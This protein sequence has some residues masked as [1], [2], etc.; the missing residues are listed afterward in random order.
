MK[1][2]EEI[3]GKLLLLKINSLWTGKM[4]F[5]QPRWKVMAK[6][7]KEFSQCEIVLKKNNFPSNSFNGEIECIFEN[8]GKK[9]LTTGRNVFAQSSDVIQR[10]TTFEKKWTTAMQWSSENIAEKIFGKVHQ[11]F[12]EC[13]KLA[14]KH[15]KQKNFLDSFHLDTK[16]VVLTTPLLFFEKMQIFVAQCAKLNRNNNF[17]WKKFSTEKV[18]PMKP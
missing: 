1:R 10:S 12:G 4:Q 2:I 9:F 13:P 11:F 15:L 5:F 17:F 3:L 16:Y 14:L 8:S 7:W 18:V 6:C